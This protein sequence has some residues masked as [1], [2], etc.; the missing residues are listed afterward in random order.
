LARRGCRLLLT[1]R[2]GDRLTTL[3][4]ELSGIEV[5][6]LAADLSDPSAPGRLLAAAEAL[7][8]VDVLV[9]NAGYAIAQPFPETA[10]AQ[11][12]EFIEVMM[13]APTQLAH[14]AARTMRRRGFGRILNVASVAGLAPPGPSGG[15][16]AASKA[17]LVRFSQAL[18]LELDGTGVHVT[19]LC[20]GLTRTEFHDAMGEGEAYR[21]LP[22]W[23]WQDADAVAEVGLEGVAANRAIV[24]PGLVNK[25]LALAARIVPDDWTSAVAR[26]QLAKARAE[27]K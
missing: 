23:L 24:I 5:H 13:R 2:R 6:V 16:Y 22:T 9:N 21:R 7:G 14:A 19:A 20:P 11:Q 1:A 26:G 15:L 4:Q 27:S 12:S 25:A 10:W 18:N 17:Y 3:A 8:G